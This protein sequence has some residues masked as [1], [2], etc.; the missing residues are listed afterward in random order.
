M[1]N[2][3]A[4]QSAISSSGRGVSLGSIHSGGA[5]LRSWWR[6]ERSLRAAPMTTIFQVTDL[7]HRGHTVRVPS[8]EIAATVSVVG[9]A[10]RAQPVGRRSCS[11]GGSR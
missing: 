11:S 1:S 8:D 2:A 5:R 4:E 9:P 3:S 7:L 10:R 6:H